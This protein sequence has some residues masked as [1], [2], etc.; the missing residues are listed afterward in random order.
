MTAQ[1]DGLTLPSA[2]IVPRHLIEER[3]LA[4]VN[5][6][7][8]LHFEAVNVIRQQGEN[9]IISGDLNNY[10]QLIVSALDV[11]VEGMALTVMGQA[12]SIAANTSASEA[13]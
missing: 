4:F 8:A 11:P 6:D 13:N 5:K 7:N 2:A 1:I 10:N 12:E 3:G 9:V